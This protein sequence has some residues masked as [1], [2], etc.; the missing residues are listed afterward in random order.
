ME[1]VV[2]V[3]GIWM[4]GIDMSLLKKRVRQCG[5]KTY[6]FSYPTVRRSPEQ[7][8]KKLQEFV[9]NI[10]SE[11]IHFVA[12]SLGG[13]VVRHLF[14][15]YPQQA[16]GNV[17]TLGTPHRGSLIAMRLMR[18]RWGR[19]ILGKSVLHGLLGGVPQWHAPN[20]LGVIAGIGRIGI[21]RFF[22]RFT[23]DNDGTV[24]V[25]ETK[26]K[27]MTDYLV[28]DSAHMGFLFNKSVAKQVCAF[29]KTGHFNSE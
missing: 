11:K 14:A 8:A 29:L 19:L 7:N 16:A 23:E 10:E 17:I 24:A 20:K 27:G 4:M 1:S 2:F 9:Q 18:Y 22:A 25:S 21:G 13:L 28:L 12:H 6:Q 15:L 26:I 5:Y 3:H